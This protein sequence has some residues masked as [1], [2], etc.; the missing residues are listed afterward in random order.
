MEKWNCGDEVSLTLKCPAYINTVKRKNQLK[1][2]K[3]N[4]T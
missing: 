3:N 2:P 1:K 4:D